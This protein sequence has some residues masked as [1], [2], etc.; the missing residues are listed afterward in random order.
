M[1]KA[2]DR[3]RT[4]THPSFVVSDHFVLIALFFLTIVCISEASPVR[5]GALG[6]EADAWHGA[7]LHKFYGPWS[8]V[9]KANGENADYNDYG[10]H[11]QDF[12]PGPENTPSYEPEEIDG[13]TGDFQ[14]NYAEIG[15]VQDPGFA[16]KTHLPDEKQ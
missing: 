8:E 4:M 9:K 10:A 16:F 2:V 1:R 6:P 12:E 14:S 15:V 3:P 7:V 13:P 11:I 5:D